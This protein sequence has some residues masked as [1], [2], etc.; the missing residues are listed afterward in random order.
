MPDAKRIL[1][2]PGEA[3]LTMLGHERIE[4]EVGAPGEYR[5]AVRWTP[6]WRVESGNV[7]L[8]RRRTG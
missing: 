1:T 6:T 5:L 4:G 8:E 7:C 2:G 3:R